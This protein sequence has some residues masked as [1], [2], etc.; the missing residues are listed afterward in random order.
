MILVDGGY[1]VANVLLDKFEKIAVAQNHKSNHGP[2]KILYYERGSGPRST[3][4]FFYNEVG[5][6]FIAKR[7]FLVTS[8]ESKEKKFKEPHFLLDE[9]YITPILS[10]HEVTSINVNLQFNIF[11]RE[12]FKKTTRMG[13]SDGFEYVNILT[14]SRPSDTSRLLI[15]LVF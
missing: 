3:E 10:L 5:D 14:M 9:F 15:N 4:G 13:K 11:S 1:L 12:F 8:G 6:F 2:F 7:E